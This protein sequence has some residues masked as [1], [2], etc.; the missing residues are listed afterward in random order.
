M[1]SKFFNRAREQ[2]AMCKPHD[3]SMDEMDANGLKRCLSVFDLIAF[4]LGSCV[5]AG[6]FVSTGQIAAFHSGAAV[7]ISYLFAGFSALLSGLCYAEFAAKLPIAGSA[8]AYSYASLGEMA[9]WL[10]GW[11]LTLEYGIS[12]GTIAVSWASY[13]VAVFFNF[14]VDMPKALTPIKLGDT[15]FQIN[16]LALLI[17]IAVT[18]LL[19]FGMNESAKFNLVMTIFNITMILFVIVYGFVMIDTD[20]WSPFMPF[21]FDEVLV[22]AGIAFFSYIGFDSVSC[23]SAEAK[24]PQRDIPLGL[25]GTLAIATTLYFLV[26]LVVAGMVPYYD[27]QLPEYVDSPI[28]QAFKYAGSDWGASLV[29]I[30]S[31][32]T[33]TCTTLCSI[34][35]QPRIFL[36]MSQDGLLW[37]FL[38]RVNK[39]QVPANG[40]I[41][42]AIIAGVLALFFTFDFLADSISLGIFMAFSFVCAGVLLLRMRYDP[43]K[44]DISLQPGRRVFKNWLPSVLITW[45]GVGT[46]A[47]WMIIRKGSVGV[48]ASVISMVVLGGIPLVGILY[49][50]YRGVLSPPGPTFQTPLMPYLPCLGLF[51]NGCLMAGLSYSSYYNVIIWTVAGLL[52]YFSYGFNHSNVYRNAL[53]ERQKEMAGESDRIG[54]DFGGGAGPAAY[55]EKQDKAVDETE[56]SEKLNP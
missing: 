21:G 35:G 52:V 10:M 26:G 7:C 51:V 43:D 31:C 42:T 23:M 14:G 18:F 28:S 16:L 25:L 54:Y 36:A 11:N 2:F 30:T 39:R 46:W 9:A 37:P 50:W 45:F 47:A 41:F 34:M 4:G 12:A 19:L 40:T 53:L 13:F 33:L 29:A 17:V 24:N 8:Y 44:V 27:L 1:A 38:G 22:G 56:T 15:I 32:T 5:G 3:L 49:M 48:A 20:N 6:V 55:G